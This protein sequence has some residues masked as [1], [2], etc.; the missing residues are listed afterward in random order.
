MPEIG[1]NSRS[2]LD[3][4]MRNLSN[5]A[6][7]LPR[8]DARVYWKYFFSIR[9]SFAYVGPA[10]VLT[11]HRSQGSTFKEVYIAADIF[12]S[13]DLSLRRQLAYVAVSRASKKVWL[14][15]NKYEN[16]LNSMWEKELKL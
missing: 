1:S 16:F 7:N 12:L 8:K 15:G 2:L 4:I 5:K 3:E 10:S 13:K 9:D 14:V 11:V 6:K